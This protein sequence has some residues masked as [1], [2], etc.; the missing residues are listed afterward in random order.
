MWTVLRSRD[1][2]GRLRTFY[3]IRFHLYYKYF[4]FITFWYPIWDT[5]ILTIYCTFITLCADYMVELQLLLIHLICSCCQASPS[6]LIC[7]ICWQW[8]GPFLLFYTIICGCCQASP[9][10]LT[11]AAFADEAAAQICSCW[12]AA[13]WLLIAAQALLHCCWCSCCSFGFLFLGFRTAAAS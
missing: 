9:S 2:I 10:L 5:Y 6:L 8:P 3:S 7:C 4:F 12:S 1:F 13:A 11:I